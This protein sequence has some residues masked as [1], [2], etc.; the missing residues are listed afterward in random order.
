MV[1][2]QFSEEILLVDGDRIALFSEIDTYVVTKTEGVWLI[3]A[4]NMKE[5][6]P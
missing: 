3:A 4:H 2:W 6:K 1:S 5:K